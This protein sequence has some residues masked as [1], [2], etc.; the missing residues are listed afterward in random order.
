MTTETE[1]A[2]MRHN[3]P[4]GSAAVSY[5]SCGPAIRGTRGC[6]LMRSRRHEQERAR[7]AHRRVGPRHR[8]Q[9]RDTPAGLSTSS[10]ASQLPL[11]NVVA[12]SYRF[13]SKRRSASQPQAVIVTNVST[14]PS[15]PATADSKGLG[16]TLSGPLRLRH[17]WPLCGTK[18]DSG[19]PV[20]YAA[21]GRYSIR[22]EYMILRSF[23]FLRL[24][25]EDENASQNKNC[26]SRRCAVTAHCQTAL[27]MR[28]VQKVAY[29]S[30]KWSG[31]NESCP[32]QC[33]M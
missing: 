22:L 25:R 16:S 19:D 8:K 30:A 21:S 3:L 20:C 33:G 24:L 12:I 1:G 10:N 5:R 14:D 26:E 32:K 28:L 17:I 15:W 23:D 31:K 18:A 6:Q 2:G 9:V 29:G 7:H 4:R 13:S 11:K 27:G